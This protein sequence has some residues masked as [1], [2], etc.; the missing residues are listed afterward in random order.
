MAGALY[1]RCPVGLVDRPKNPFYFSLACDALR[2]HALL[3][4]GATLCV[5]L[6]FTFSLAFLHPS[7]LVESI[8]LIRFDLLVHDSCLLWVIKVTA[9]VSP[10]REDL[11]EV[12]VEAC[13]LWS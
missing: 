10:P 1:G 13:H 5:R 12:L 11:Q 3:V 4:A 9:V 6:L 8:A 2:K 7:W